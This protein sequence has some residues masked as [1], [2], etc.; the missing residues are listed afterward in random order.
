MGLNFL[1]ISPTCYAYYAETTSCD[2]P[3]LLFKSILSRKQ[4]I[5]SDEYPRE[6][7]RGKNFNYNYYDPE[8]RDN[9]RLRKLVEGFSRTFL[10]NFLRLKLILLRKTFV[11]FKMSEKVGINLDEQDGS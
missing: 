8:M 10:G 2:L 9:N 1:E 6:I 5:N 7:N 4:I 11:S 3:I